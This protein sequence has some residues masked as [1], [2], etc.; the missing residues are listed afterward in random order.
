M[1]KNISRT[2]CPSHFSTL[3][4]IKQ[5]F[6]LDKV[7]LEHNYNLHEVWNIKLKYCVKTVKMAILSDGMLASLLN[8][9]FQI[10]GNKTL[11]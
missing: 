1:G 11:G 5:D 2:S 9:I 4:D 3:C 10:R 7:T 8:R 6:N